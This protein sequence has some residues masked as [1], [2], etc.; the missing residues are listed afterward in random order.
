MLFKE[1]GEIACLFPSNKTQKTWEPKKKP[2][3]F[4]KSKKSSVSEGKQDIDQHS[5]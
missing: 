5:N 4:D 3:K 1:D 2:T